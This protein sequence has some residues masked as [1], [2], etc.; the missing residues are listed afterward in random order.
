MDIGTS[1]AFK[2]TLLGAKSIGMNRQGAS[3]A[4]F[5]ALFEKLGIAAEVRPKVKLLDGAAGEAV[6]KGEVELGLTQISE[7][8][9]YAE[10]Q[11]AAL[12]AEI[13]TYTTFSAGIAAASK[14]SDAAKSLIRF[15]TA[16]GAVPVI[17]AK[18]MEP[19]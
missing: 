1:A 16:P 8:L 13:Q 17:R 4:T 18:G 19:G 12:P 7:L 15:L 5:N 14:E 9:P 3:A 10:D 2:R 6:A 11:A